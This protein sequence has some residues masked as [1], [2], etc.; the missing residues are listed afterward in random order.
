M[1]LKITGGKSDNETLATPWRLRPTTTKWKDLADIIMLC[2]M[3]VGVA[4]A[5]VAERR[6]SV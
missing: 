1:G 5:A 2:V 4:G 6:Y 3:M